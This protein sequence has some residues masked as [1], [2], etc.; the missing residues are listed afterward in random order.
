MPVGDVCP[1]VPAQDDLSPEGYKNLF[2]K[3]PAGPEN[4]AAAQASPIIEESKEP[5]AVSGGELDYDTSTPEE[6]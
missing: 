2:A 3:Q 5:A 1:I 6:R 4:S